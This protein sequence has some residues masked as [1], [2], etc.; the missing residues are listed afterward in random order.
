[1]RFSAI[2]ILGGVLLA[3]CTPDFARRNDSNLIMRI[4]DIE[5]IP[6]GEGQEDGAILHSDVSQVV[7][8]IA[9]VEVELLRK[10]VLASS[11][12][13]EDVILTRYEVRYFRTDGRNREGID[14]PFRI[15]GP[16][17]VRIHAPSG[18]GESTGTAVIDVV[19]HQAK[20]EPPLFNMVGAFLPGGGAN[21]TPPI[22]TGTGIMTTVA[23]ITV[24]GVATNDRELSATGQLQV[25]FA[26]FADE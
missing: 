17:N 20:I 9:E 1:M 4:S 8:D 12:P 2:A 24:Y 3:G 23:E 18:T 14:V 7:N 21:R 22:I 11:S 19:R 26:D 10:N 15:T 13:L 6:G 25:T 5:G 16:L